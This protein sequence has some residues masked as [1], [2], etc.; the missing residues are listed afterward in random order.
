MNVIQLTQL[1]YLLVE[2][3]HKGHKIFYSNKQETVSINSLVC[4]AGDTPSLKVYLSNKELIRF[5]DN[6]IAF[7]HPTIGLQLHKIK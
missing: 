1:F 7:M 2:S 5:P 3:S 6:G 4:V